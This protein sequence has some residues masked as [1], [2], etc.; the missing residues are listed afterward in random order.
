MVVLAIGPEA[1]VDKRGFNRTV[2]RAQ[3]RFAG[4]EQPKKKGGKR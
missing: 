4:I 3:E 1:E 2:K